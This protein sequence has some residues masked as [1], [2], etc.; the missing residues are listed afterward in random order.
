MYQRDRVRVAVLL[1]SAA[2]V[3]LGVA[4]VWLHLAS[5]SDGA[6]LNPNQHT[7]RSHGVAVTVLRAQPDGLR[8]GDVVVAVDGKSVESWA[9]ALTNPTTARPHWHAGQVVTYTVERGGVTMDVPVTLGSYPVDAVWQE[10]WST[11]IFALVFALIAL[12]VALRRPRDRAP[13][14]LL[15]SACGILGATTWTFGL[16]V[17][18]LIGGIGFWLYK[19]TTSVDFLLFYIAALHFDLVFPKRNAMLA[20]HPWLI[21]ALYLTPF[22]LDALYLSAT[23]LTASHVLD[24]IGS[25]NDVENLIVVALALAIVVTI[26]WTYRTNRDADTRIKIRWVVFGCLVSIVAGLLLWDLPSNVLGH[27]LIST[28]ALGLLVLPLPLS[29]AIAI[30]RH[31]LFDIDTILNRTL[32]Y[33]SL[34]G[35]VAGIYVVLVGMLGIIFQAQGNLLIALVAAGAVAV[36][37]QPLRLWL[38]RLVDR[39]MFGE[40]DNPYAVL[41]RLGRRLEAV[42]A[43]EAVLPTIVETVAHA[44]K[45]PAVAIAIKEDDQ[46]TLGVEYGV[47]AGGQVTWPLVYQSELVG[48]LRASPRAPNEA[49]TEADKRLLADIAHQLGI[50][51]HATRL[52]TDL[53][54]SRERLVTAREEERRRLRRDLHDGL[55]PTLAALALK[56]TTISDLIPTDQTA[57]TELANELY[58]DIRTTIVEI[59][60]LVYELRPPAL[61]DLGLVAALRESALKSSSLRHVRDT[62][63]GDGALRIIVEAPDHVPPLPAAVEVAAYRIVQEALTN[64]VRHAEAHT[65]TIHLSL[66][67][68]LQIEVRDDGVGFSS[69]RQTG[70]GLLSMRE[71][72]AELGGSCVIESLPGTGTHI[73]ARLPV[74]K[75]D[76]DGATPRPDRG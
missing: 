56:A 35:I 75:E 68:T 67:D 16:Q 46:L 54:R 27:P 69:E 60:R 15:V 10:G 58:G 11:I 18:D 65:C 73:R 62:S 43:P 41:S 42:L 64:V 8:T 30:L 45:L 29:I 24:W 53:Q 32:V 66:A 5:P 70:V 72:A 12:Y 33:G 47:S 61:D 55:G 59:R 38:Q 20:S 19:A 3:A 49:F 23:R 39:L 22:M 71:R 57:A 9:Q 40:R 31:R 48:E 21:G 52:T 25:A 4:F 37:F 7:W 76:T 14:V 36:L 6:R 1:A 2:M 34:S 51:V 17:S 74:P 50:A 44:L 26:I 63:H 13:L 28:N